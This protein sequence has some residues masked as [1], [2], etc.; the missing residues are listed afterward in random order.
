M[1]HSVQN[2][3]GLAYIW[4]IRKVITLQKKKHR[5]TYLNCVYRQVQTFDG[6]RSLIPMLAIAESRRCPA[7][8]NRACNILLGPSIS[9]HTS[10]PREKLGIIIRTISDCLI[11]TCKKLVYLLQVS[12]ILSNML[13]VVAAFGLLDMSDFK[14]NTTSIHTADQPTVCWLTT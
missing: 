7:L 1:L 12:C 11:D 9:T 8:C 10:S 3:L 6:M 13:N 5:H 14:F 2:K 4:P